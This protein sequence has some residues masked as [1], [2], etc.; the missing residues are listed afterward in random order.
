MYRFL[1]AIREWL[2][3]I[4]VIVWGVWLLFKWLFAEFLRQKKESPSL[5]GKLLART[6]PCGNHRLL[7]TVEARWNNH[8]PLSIF[9]DLDKCRIDIFRIDSSKFKEEGVVELRSDLGEL[10]CTH[11]FL[12]GKQLKSYRFEPKTASTIMNHF[13]LQPGIYGIRMEL[14]RKEGGRWW[15]ELVLDLRATHQNPLPEAHA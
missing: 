5:D 14:F 12:Q 7:V 6:I 10:I 13:V 8:S 11:R 1:L 2:P 15:K 3:S 9:L 4:A